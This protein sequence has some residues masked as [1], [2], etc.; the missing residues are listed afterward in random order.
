MMRSRWFVASGAFLALI[1][2]LGI[3]LGFS[4]GGATSHVA[5]TTTTTSPPTTTPA[6]HTECHPTDRSQTVPNTAPAGVTWELF[7]SVALPYSKTAGPLLVDGQGAHC[8]AHTPTGALLAAVQIGT[9]SQL[10]AQWRQVDLKQVL[11]GPGRDRLMTELAQVA[12]FDPP[13]GGYGQLAGFRFQSY[14]ADEATIEF[15]N[16]FQSGAMQMTAATVRWSD[17]DWKLQLQPD[18]GT[19]ATAQPVPDL[20]GF[21]PWG[22]V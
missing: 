15:V 12:S 7:N 6:P 13:D 9:R 11:P 19:S 1:G 21:V 3:W 8:F 17:G 2:V 16:R 20:T 22:G 18:G 5:A 14:D 10:S 4:G